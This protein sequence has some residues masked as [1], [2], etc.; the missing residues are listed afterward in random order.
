[1][2]RL[3][4]LAGLL[5][6]SWAGAAAAQ[7]AEQI[8]MRDFFRNPDRAYYRISGDGKT[9]SFMQP[10]ERRMNV[11]IQPVG[12]SQDPVRI[13]SEKDRDITDYFWK[14]ANRVV[15]LKDVGGDENDHVVVVD[16]RGGY[17]RMAPQRFPPLTRCSPVEQYVVEHTGRP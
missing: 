8:P 17:S 16:R 13:T 15:Y 3:L 12:S 1:M 6:L 5:L 4:S 10:W 9:L 2:N 11:F 14:G 7:S